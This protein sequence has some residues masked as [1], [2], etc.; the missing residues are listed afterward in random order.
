MTTG[1]KFLAFTA[2]LCLLLINGC[3]DE[4]S[5][6]SKGTIVISLTDAPFNYE[7]LE[8]ANVTINKIELRK[9]SRE[10]SSFIVLS[11]N[12]MNVNLVDLQ[13]GITKELVNLE[14]AAGDYDLLRLYITKSSV[15]LKE[16][17][18]F[19]LKVPSSMQSGL[20][21]F[22]NPDLSVTGGLTT[23]LLL[24][25]DVSKSFVPK[26]N[27][28]LSSFNGFNFKP[29]IRAVNQSLAGRIEGV[30]TDSNNVEIPKAMVW[31]EKDTVVSSTLS[32]E[33]GFYALVGLPTGQYILYS[34]KD[35]YDTLI[36]EA[37]NVD[38][39]NKTTVDVEINGI[40]Q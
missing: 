8:E 12:E 7:L 5:D 40:T 29:V 16:G 4:T 30:V 2:V 39:A 13:N 1:R 10:G 31:V 38:V 22:V 34:T 24:D 6:M 20:K 15:R 19:D 35:G 14:V 9:K 32:D 28:K 18:E 36:V 37:V 23:E 27:I 11:E 3:K 17:A 25:F 21:V 33:D 26:G